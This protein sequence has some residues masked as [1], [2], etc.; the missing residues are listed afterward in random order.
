[1][2]PVDEFDERETI[3]VNKQITKEFEAEKA[4]EKNGILLLQTNNRSTVA[5]RL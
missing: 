5:H 1:M 2:G 3:R 4:K